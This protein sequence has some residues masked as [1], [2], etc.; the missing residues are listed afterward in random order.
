MLDQLA[1]IVF[2]RPRGVL[3][4]GAGLLLLG[5]LIGAP[6]VGLLSSSTSGFEDPSSESV[7][8]RELLERAAGVNPEIGVVALVRL[9][10][11][12]ESPGSRAKLLDVADT[13]SAD[14]AVAVVSGFL[15]AGEDAF[16]SRDRRASYLVAAMLPVSDEGE[17]D[18][19][20]RI[21][22][23]LEDDPAVTLGGRIIG[24][25]Q[26]REQVSS[27]L[28]RAEMLAF[29]F[30]FVLSLLLFRGVVASA[31]PLLSGG[32]TILLSFLSLR[33]VNEITVLSVF[34]VNL[35]IGLSLGLAIDYSL[36]IVSRYREELAKGGR[37]REA[38]TT[39]LQT[40]GRTVA[41][42][43]LT[44]AVAMAVLL[45]FPQP[46]LYSMGIGGVAAALISG[47]T[48]LTVLPAALVLLGTRVNA[49]APRRWQV[50]SMGDKRDRAGGFWYRLAKGVMRRP[51]R[52]ALASAALLIVLGIP[53]LRV[54]FTAVD[55]EVLPE[56]KSARQVAV[57][58]ETDFPPQRTAPIYVSVAAPAAAVEDIRSLANEIGRLPGVSR[59]SMPQPV[60]A[61]LWQISVISSTTGL[62]DPSLELVR[63]IRTLDVP[64][65]L[66]VGGFAAGFLDQ[67]SSLADRLP[68]ALAILIVTTLI[69]LF[70]MTGSVVLPIKALVMNFLTLSA[71]FGVM[72]LIFQDGRLEGLLDFTSQGALEMTQ[73]ILLFAVAFAL[74]TDYAIFL[75]TRIKEAYDT[76]LSNRESVARGLE[77]TGRI[78]T[79]AALLF[80]VAIGAF[81]TSEIVF[82]KLLGLG[83]AVAVI[84]DAT[85]V[86]AFLVPSLMALLGKWNWWAPTPLRRLHERFGLH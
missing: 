8:T 73:P 37:G 66:G 5:A 1:N 80:T 44:V 55:A 36:L 19:A 43:A 48:A 52:V 83:T 81:S 78:I 16:V 21:Q 30:L 31:L 13:I 27:D 54:E 60:G 68:I 70:A 18:A 28:A 22:R 86:R 4:V 41:Y 77:R 34:A 35:V 11:T 29:P 63:S 26:M 3:A 33:I 14:P 17:I 76:G 57:A 58:L 47:I 85:L 40:A 2:R 67:R 56:S 69:L 25:Q 51:G 9:P 24:S 71:A 82:I 59:V 32:L 6:V 38:I 39:T 64:Y 53:F 42:S 72:V 20:E 15:E 62:E 23:Q 75:L 46:F 61:E 7:I 10:E 79:S 74:S 12:V 50:A 49:L 45:V 65:E 84:L